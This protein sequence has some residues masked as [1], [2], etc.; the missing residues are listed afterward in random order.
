MA[1]TSDIMEP[2][3]AEN[4]YLDTGKVDNYFHDVREGKIA[5]GSREHEL[6]PTPLGQIRVPDHDHDDGFNLLTNS[7][8]LGKNQGEISPVPGTNDKTT[9]VTIRDELQLHDVDHARGR[10]RERPRGLG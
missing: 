8:A 9:K 10:L 7:A 4:N 1:E 6:S 5:D 2:E 3:N